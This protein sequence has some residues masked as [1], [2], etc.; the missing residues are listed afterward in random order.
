MPEHHQAFHVLQEALV[1]VPV[2]GYLNFNREFVLETD[3]SLSLLGTMLFQ[4]DESGKLC[5][6]VYASLSLHPSERSMHNYSPAKL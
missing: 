6:I 3:A 4:Q 2:L 5:V 1:T